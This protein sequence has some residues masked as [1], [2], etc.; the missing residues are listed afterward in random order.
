M[1]NIR[2]RLFM[3]SL[4]SF[5]YISFSL[6]GQGPLPREA[7]APA[8]LGADQGCGPAGNP[9]AQPL[10]P[11]SRRKLILRALGQASPSERIM[12]ENATGRGYVTNPGFSRP[13]ISCSG[14]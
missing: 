6:L 7:R 11:P 1:Q 5:R 4:S 13:G 3:A 10:N 14:Q 9:A 2:L 12:H 8:G